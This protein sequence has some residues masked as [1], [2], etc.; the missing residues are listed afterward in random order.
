MSQQQQQVN[1]A[2][3]GDVNIDYLAINRARWDERAPHVSYVLRVSH[4]CCYIVLPNVFTLTLL[5]HNTIHKT[6]RHVPRLP[7][8][9]PRLR[10]LSSLVHSGLRRP[11]PPFSHRQESRP[12]PMPHRHRHP[13]A[14]APRSFSRSRP[15]PQPCESARSAE[16]SFEHCW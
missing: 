1:T 13:L 12:P 14:R 8:R 3:S 6:A 5:A 11:T 4:I 16:N 9:Q 10:S 2:E 15:G 7:R